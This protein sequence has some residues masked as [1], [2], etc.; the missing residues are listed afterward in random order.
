MKLK[1]TIAAAI[2][3]TLSAAPAA[4]ASPF[5]YGLA[6]VP[7]PAVVVDPLVQPARV[8]CDPYTGR[9]WRT[10]PRVYAPPVVAVPPVVLYPRHRHW[11][12]YRR[13]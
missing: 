6:V 3:A 1:F 2:A 10:Y 5:G 4:E 8:V 7:A 9:C 12:H 13:W 11:G